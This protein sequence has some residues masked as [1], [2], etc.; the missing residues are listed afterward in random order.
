MVAC[1]SPEA[2]TATTSPPVSTTTTTTAVVDPLDEHLDW[3]LT[4]LNGAEVSA[5]EYEAR[6]DEAFR[7][8]VPY[9]D[10]L[11]PIVADLQVAGPYELGETNRRSATGLDAIV[12]SSD[13]I[14]FLVVLD[15]NDRN[16]IVGLLVQP[17]D[18]PVLENPPQTL[19]EA[20]SRLGEFGEASLLA[21]EVLDGAC[22][23]IEAVNAEKPVPI[24]SAFKLYVL[25][26]LADAIEAGAFAW[27]DEITI[28][29]E[30]K[31][32]PSGELQ[33]RPTGSA[34][35]VREA[36]ELMISISDNTGTDLLIDLVGRDNV[37]AAQAT[38]G[39]T[40]PAL[41]IPFLTTREWAILKL[42]TE[43]QREEYL[44]AEETT[45]RQILE[46]FENV[47]ASSISG[48]FLDPI[49]PDRLEWFASLND[50]CTAHIR[51][52]ERARVP[53]LEPVAEILALNPGIPTARWDYIA[54][55]GGSEP[56]LVTTT[57]LVREESASSSSGRRSWT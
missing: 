55:K 52:Q 41:N 57:W 5:A 32:V 22:V 38:Y 25:G 42:G 18:P 36:A 24:G 30:L 44:A 15:I 7:Q 43:E 6:F 2:T 11:L 49:A 16:R 4:V 33:N 1:S 19:A 21:A 8:A 56:G 20:A 14:R 48:A 31:S 23:P 53:G 28:T 27:T 51:L 54:F 34:V 17:A 47:L 12:T 29:E 46:S 26:A 45:R 50:L 40:Q 13:S 10:A 35:T 3:F 9:E 39:H 37:E